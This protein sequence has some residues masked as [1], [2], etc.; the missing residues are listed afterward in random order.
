MST[1][2]PTPGESNDTVRSHWRM[3]SREMVGM[4]L[5]SAANDG[6]MAATLTLVALAATGHLGDFATTPGALAVLGGAVALRA[7]QW[8]VGRR[9]QTSSTAT[10]AE[11]PA[12]VN[13]VRSECISIGTHAATTSFAIQ[14]ALQL[15]DENATL[16]HTIL[17][18]TQETTSAID[19]VTMNVQQIAAAVEESLNRSRTSIEKLQSASQ[20]I[21]Q[22]DNTLGEFSCTV[23]E[24]N[25][26]ATKVQSIT[27]LIQKIAHQTNLLALNAAIEAARAGAAGRTFAVVA[28]E[29]RSL[30]EQVH[31]GANEIRESVDTTLKAVG[32]TVT[33]T[34]KISRDM[35]A[36]K[37]DVT[38]AVADC[39]SILKDLESVS[40]QT[41]QI[42]AAS[43]QMAAANSS[44][45]Q[46]VQESNTSA[47]L[48]AQG[49]RS[50]VSA[51]EELHHSTE[52]LQE[53]F[54]GFRVGQGKLEEVLAA[55]ETWTCTFEKE[56]GQ[57]AKS[58]VN[59][60]DQ[61]YQE[62]R[63]TNPKQYMVSYQPAFEAAIRPL[64]DQARTEANAQAC[65]LIDLNCYTPTHNTDFSKTPVG[66]PDLDIQF[67]RDK[68]IMNEGP[69]GRRS[70]T[71][72]GRMLL[73]IYVRDNGAVTCEL[74]IPV[75]VAG[76]RWGASRFAIDPSKL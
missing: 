21:T 35:G 76:K 52:N 2:K 59:L 8:I 30:A 64:L 20:G 37:S 7:A 27:E 68:R 60:F 39:G 32:R 16:A 70:A 69:Y 55:A 43:E 75:H 17:N 57:L 67:C 1:H 51:S 33:Q 34:E 11:L 19:S 53:V 18:S 46:S 23:R 13:T 74:A 40:G 54:S 41:N 28:S 47:A 31:T 62:I 45:L 48:L 6:A 12:L 50:T 73:Q 26:G 56:L 22:L 10:A 25:D 49:L 15:S 5:R 66:K 29:V 3:P 36:L 42:A 24:L 71:L 61:S 58:G 63:G 44:V 9:R 65:A 72:T 4:T 14:K 38:T